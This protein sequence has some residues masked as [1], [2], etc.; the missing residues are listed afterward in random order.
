MAEKEEDKAEF[1]GI[2]FGLLFGDANSLR[3]V[4][5][6]IYT[7]WSHAELLKFRRIDGYLFRECLKTMRRGKG[8]SEEDM[9]VA[10]CYFFYRRKY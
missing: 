10:E 2:F 4:P 3:T 8:C 9:V 1:W 5:S 6:W 7:V